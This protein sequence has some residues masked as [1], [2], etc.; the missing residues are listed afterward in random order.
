MAFS[1]RSRQTHLAEKVWPNRAGHS[2]RRCSIPWLVLW[3]LPYAGQ[4]AELPPGE[5]VRRA[6]AA[7]EQNDKQARNYTFHERSERRSFDK[8]GRLKSSRSKTH[9]L[10]ILDGSVYRRLIARNDQALDPKEEG[11]EQ[12]KLEKSIARMQKET[13]PQRKK[14]LAKQEKKKAVERE[15]VAEV[16][17]AY[18][19][20][21]VGEDCV[22][23]IETY[24]I[25]AQP[26]PDYKPASRRARILPKLRGTFWIAKDDYA[27]VKL[28][29]ETIKKVSFGLFL[30]KL[31]KGAKLQFEKTRVNDE[32]WLVDTFRVRFKARLGLV[33]GFNSEF[34]STYNNFR[35][36]TA[37]SRV[38]S[39]AEL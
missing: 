13:P 5:I 23:G 7:D 38:L 24:V 17:R 18:D 19:F 28:E 20:Q 30:F 21:L 2:K 14:R 26:K 34:V 10:T 12:K 9:D 33:K 8:K 32:V 15:F 25:D 6:F 39:V 36:F 11:K 29:A 16:Q 35:K 22:D 3:L 4:S 37:S 31:N 1:E 27:W